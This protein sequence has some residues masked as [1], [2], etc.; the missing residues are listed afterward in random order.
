MSRKIWKDRCINPYE[1]E[2]V[3]HHT[4]TNFRKIS[5][6]L[7]KAKPYLPKNSVV[8]NDC[9]LQRFAKKA[10]MIT[11]NNT[12]ISADDVQ[13]TENAP[14]TVEDN[15][16]TTRLLELEELL[17][18]LKDAFSSL[19]GND[20]MKIKILTICPKSWGIRKIAREFNTTTY[21]AMKAKELRSIKGI[22][23]DATAKRGKTLPEET[24]KKIDDFYND[25]SNGRLLPGRKDVVSVAI[26]DV[27]VKVQKRLLLMGLNE[28][29]ELFIQSYPTKVISFSAFAK[30][31]P[32]HCI[33]P[34][35]NGTHCV[36]VCTIHENCKLM[37]DAINVAK[38][39][40]QLES[41]INNYNDCVQSIVCKNP[42][43]D[44][45][46]DLCDQCPTADNISHLLTEALR[47]ASID[48]IEYSAWITTGRAT[49][50]TI[51]ADVN[52][53]VAEFCTRLQILK[54][55]S[56][57]AKHQS[58]F[59]SEKKTELRDDEVIVM[60]DFSE[61]FAYVVQNASQAFHF[62]NEQCTVFPVIYYYKDKSELKHNCCVFLSNSVK[63]DTAA[64]YTIQKQLIPEIKKTVPKVKT[65][66]YMTDG[67]K[68][69][70][71]NKYQMANLINHKDDFGLDAEWHYSAT[72]HGKSGYDGLGA[73]FKREAYR[74][75]LMAKP[76][77]A[78]LTSVALF[79]WAKNH[80]KKINIFYFSIVDH[81]K[82]TRHLNKRFNSAI[83]VR[84]ILKLHSFKVVAPNTLC[85]KR[86]SNDQRG[87][88]IQLK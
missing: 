51:K 8:C 32:P 35:A 49:L 7:L 79:N 62:N 9:R 73:T 28:L 43:S 42:T 59:I 56:F 20:P 39:T 15:S 81:D 13:C 24:K 46:L 68:Q 22:L 47:N 80:F 37:L 82:S 52:D 76:S 40:E 30:L 66:I 67:A 77:Q 60:F 88:E 16:S 26:N 83:P 65:L 71:K 36:C 58:Q 5:E 53:F 27:R 45:F 87:V 63:H 10:K 12:N 44:C 78:L 31:R 34:G 23:A 85:A 57:I 72:A 3:A 17:Q 64:V 50:Q 55:H 54:P 48:E 41:P 33:L 14:S 74:A 18:G 70:F 84:N 69:H 75:S 19:E 1:D 38:L 86:F 2:G 4:G 29:H 61:N 11:E 25:D 6:N 21:L